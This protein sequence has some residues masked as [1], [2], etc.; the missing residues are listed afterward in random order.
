[1]ATFSAVTRQHILQAIAEH[2]SRG[3]EDFLGVYGFG[4]TDTATFEHEGKQYPTLAILGVAHRF[5]T[6]RLATADEF[7][8]G[9]ASAQALL[10]RRGFTVPVPERAA[11]PVRAV[12]AKAP[13]R[14]RAA[15]TTSTRAVKREPVEI[16]CPTCFTILPATGICDS[17][18]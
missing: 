2:R 1:M 4:G 12:K 11:T 7:H 16:A 14:P 18:G 8:G 13:A 5:A 10:G 15:S 17:C 6:G 9:E 3:A